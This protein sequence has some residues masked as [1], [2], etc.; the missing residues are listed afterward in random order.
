MKDKAMAI[1]AVL[2]VLVIIP[3]MTSIAGLA[4][5]VIAGYVLWN[6]ERVMKTWAD[7]KEVI[8][9]RPE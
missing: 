3:I 5:A 8:R 9:G 1:F 7:V 6:R 4:L 2:A